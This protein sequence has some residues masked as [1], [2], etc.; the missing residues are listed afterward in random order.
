M[1]FFTRFSDG[2]ANIVSGLGT[3]NDRRTYAHYVV[4]PLSW[5]EIA[6]AYRTSWMIRKGVNLPPYDMTRAG[7]DWQADKST[8]ALL[9]KEEER[10]GL[11][12]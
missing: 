1:G 9:E 3:T 6:A 11:W 7:R 8:I 5:V 2:L 4:R 12:A 10:I